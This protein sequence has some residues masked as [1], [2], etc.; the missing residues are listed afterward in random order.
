MCMHVHACACMCMCT[1]LKGT[2]AAFFSSC[3]WPVICFFD[4]GSFPLTCLFFLSFLSL[5]ARSVGLRIRPN[6]YGNDCLPS[7]NLLPKRSAIRTNSCAS[8]PAIALAIPVPLT[9]ICST[10]GLVE[11][12]ISS[13]GEPATCAPSMSTS[14]CPPHTRAY[15]P[16]ARTALAGEGAQGGTQMRARVVSAGK[17]VRRVRARRER[18][19]SAS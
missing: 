16:N 11:C 17:N 1:P 4:V 8:E 19:V 7:S 13:V 5:I 9:D 6:E 15:I 18:V 10:A 14:S 12:T 2:E 3:G